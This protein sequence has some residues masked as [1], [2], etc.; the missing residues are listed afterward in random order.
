MAVDVVDT[1]PAR[2]HSTAY[3]RTAP[4]IISV[5]IIFRPMKSGAGRPGVSPTKFLQDLGGND[6]TRSGIP[7]VKWKPLE[8]FE[9]PTRLVGDSR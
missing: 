4:S 7:A 3:K 9:R 8:K 2:Q 6:Q 1:V 5:I